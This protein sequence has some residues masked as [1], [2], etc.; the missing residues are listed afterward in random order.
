MKTNKKIII[1]TIFSA[2]IS[3]TAFAQSNWSSIL[4][5]GLSA[6]IAHQKTDGDS[7][8][9]AGIGG[10]VEYLAM[11]K[12][13]G[14]SFLANF[15]GAAIFSD[16]LTQKN[17]IGGLVNFFGGIGYS[18][19]RTEK[20]SL[21]L[22]G[23][24]GFDYYR[25]QISNSDSDFSISGLNLLT[26]I[27][28]CFAMRLS[29]HLGIGFNVLGTVDLVGVNSID[30][31]LNDNPR[32]DEYEDTRNKLVKAGSLSLIPSVCLTIHF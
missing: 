7:M 4:F 23:G 25:Y 8:N 9:Y 5:V 20:L 11:N 29:K 26:G 31:D 19:L 1:L 12:N 3:A 10:N 21:S 15:T 13:N 28:I 32:N 16:D 6:P 27:D 22:T 30:R 2:V 24:I 18:P 14:L 17:E